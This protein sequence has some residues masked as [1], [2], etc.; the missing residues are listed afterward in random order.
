M[1]LWWPLD[2]RSFQEYSRFG[3]SKNVLS[4]LI[5]H[6]VLMVQLCSGIKTN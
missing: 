1:D 6:V 2:K 4:K 5:C 3:G